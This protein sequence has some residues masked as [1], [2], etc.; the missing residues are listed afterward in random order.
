MILKTK[1]TNFNFLIEGIP[2][3]ATSQVLET[4][5]KDEFGAKDYRKILSL[6]LDH[7]SR[8]L[9]VVCLYMIL[10]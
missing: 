9:W 6:K 8:P 3:A 1:H 10:C 4:A 7:T 2:K 5:Q